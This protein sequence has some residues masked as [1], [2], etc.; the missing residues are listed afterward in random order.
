[1]SELGD[2]A[3]AAYEVE[4]AIP[5]RQCDPTQRGCGAWLPLNDTFFHRDGEGFRHVCKICRNKHEEERRILRGAELIKQIDDHAMGLLSKACE[6][7]GSSLP[8]MSEIFE[9]FMRAMGGPQGYVNHVMASM[10]AAPAGGVTRQK[11]HDMMFRM[12]MKLSEGGHI[13]KNVEQMSDEEIFG[14]A[15]VVMRELQKRQREEQPREAKTTGV[16]SLAHIEDHG[17]KA[18]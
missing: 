5:R 12:S 2:R 17:P 10:L 18:S 8:H 14:K 16:P 6:R 9:L 13:E 4:D 11:Y 3:R 1:M 7:G 15:A